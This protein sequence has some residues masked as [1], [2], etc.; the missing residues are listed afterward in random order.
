MIE[1]SAK[2]VLINKTFLSINTGNKKLVDPGVTLLF[3]D[4]RNIV[5][6]S[7]LLMKSTTPIASLDANIDVI[8]TFPVEDRVTVVSVNPGPCVILHFLV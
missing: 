3:T 7:S 4:A 1:V 8:I 5:K 6:P 2:F